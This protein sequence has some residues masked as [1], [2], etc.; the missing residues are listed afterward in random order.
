MPVL[1]TTQDLVKVMDGNDK[2][3]EMMKEADKIELM[4]KTKNIILLNILDKVLMEV[5]KAKDVTVSWEK[6][7]LP[8]M[9]KVWNNRLY[10]RI[11]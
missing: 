9:M 1:L 4:D 3:L 7:E 6:F 11:V 10:I 5:A 2:L 8:Y